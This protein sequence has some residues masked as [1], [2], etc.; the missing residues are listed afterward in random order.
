MVKNAKNDSVPGLDL[1][2]DQGVDVTDL[3]L[4]HVLVAGDAEVEAVLETVEDVTEVIQDQDLVIGDDLEVLEE[5]EVIPEVDLGPDLDL[6]V[7]DLGAEPE[8]IQEVGLEVGLVEDK[9]FIH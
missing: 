1:V 5:E 8:A 7:T 2:L 3:D 4:A 6:E 9:N